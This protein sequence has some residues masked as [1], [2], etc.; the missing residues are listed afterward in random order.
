MSK[1]NKNLTLKNETIDL[2]L[3]HGY[4]LLLEF[5]KAQYLGFFSL[6]SF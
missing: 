3:V 5:Q 2:V 4:K 1:A 6:T